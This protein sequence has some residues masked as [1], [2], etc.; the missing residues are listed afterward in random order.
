[1]AEK[2]RRSTWSKFAPQISVA[3]WRLH[4]LTLFVLAT[5]AT[6][7]A[8]IWLW[9]SNE[10]ELLD[11]STFQLT[12]EKL[13]VTPQ[14]DF[15]KIDLKKAAFDGSGLAE[16][17]LLD[18]DLVSKVHAA[19]AVQSWVEQAIVRKNRSAVDV[20]L[21][22]RKPVALVEFG[23]NLL[24]PIDRSG[25]VLDGEDFNSALAD[26]FVRIT[27]ESPQVGSLV[28]G[29][30]WPDERIVAAA[31]IAELILPK[32]KDW[33]IVRIAHVPLTSGSNAPE[34]DFEF[35]TSQNTAGIRVLWGSPPGFERTDEVS[36]AQK[37][38]TLSQWISERGSLTDFGSSQ[39][40]DLR[41]GQIKLVSKR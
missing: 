37:L 21:I 7:V 38:E 18:H 20:D 8:G 36:P 14:P 27:V 25:I 17:N 33:G 9:R 1:M 28:H 31:M 4:P 26:Q 11:R 29:D 3:D 5:V 23:D 6:I 24:L 12:F 39:T 15:L 41:S 19:F 30:A 13:V 10:S 40:I 34:G 16:T 22:F 32:A 2:K 35:L